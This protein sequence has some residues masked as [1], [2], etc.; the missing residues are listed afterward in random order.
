M[1]FHVRNTDM[2]NARGRSAS[3]VTSPSAN[4]NLFCGS[5]NTGSLAVGTPSSNRTSL[6]WN[7]SG[8]TVVGTLTAS[9]VSNGGAGVSVTE[10][11]TVPKLV[12]PNAPS[13]TGKV[14]ELQQGAALPIGAI[15][16]WTNQS[17]YPPGNW[18]PCYGDAFSRNGY[19]KLF[20]VLGTAYGSG[21]GSTTFNLPNLGG[22]YP[23]GFDGYGNDSNFST[24]GHSGGQSNTQLTVAN[25]PAHSHG[26]NDNGHS[27][28]YTTYPS[29]QYAATNSGTHGPSYDLN[30]PQQSTSTTSSTYISIQSTGGGQAVNTLSPYTVVKYLIATD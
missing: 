26:V 28:G 11:T 24:F 10:T 4:L 3:S 13:F 6:Q 8:V 16:M 27:H 19:P 22:R 20:A 2:G 14:T 1:A 18:L 21:D 29:R 25:M 15:I 17:N 9:T 30:Y 7:L 12:L 23:A 5:G